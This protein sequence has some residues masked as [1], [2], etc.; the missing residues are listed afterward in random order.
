MTQGV[1]TFERAQI[2]DQDDSGVC[3]L[4]R[5]GEDYIP[6]ELGKSA[7]KIMHKVHIP[8]E[9]TPWQ[10]RE[11]VCG[12]YFYLWSKPLTNYYHCILDGL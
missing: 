8:L 6:L 2:Y 4:M 7:R 10:Q 11:V 12:N 3:E 5:V 1:A 9:Q